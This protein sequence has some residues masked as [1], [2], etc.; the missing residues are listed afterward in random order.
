[1]IRRRIVLSYWIVALGLF[2]P[3]AVFAYIDPATTTYIIQIIT[4]LVVTVGV[5]LSILL[6]RFRMV[7]AKIRYGLYGLLYRLRRE[8]KGDVP[9][10]L[11]G[12]EAETKGDVPCVLPG[13]EGPSELPESAGLLRSARNDE[14]GDFEK[15]EKTKG[16]VP[17]VLPGGEGPSELSASAELLR[18]ARYDEGE[19]VPGGGLPEFALPGYAL[20][21]YA[22]PGAGHPP[23]DEEMAAL[24]EPAGLE[25]MAQT[26]PWTDPADRGFPGRLKAAAPVSFAIAFSFVLIGCLDLAVQN[27][28]DI[29]FRPGEITPALLLLS[30]A[31]SIILLFALALFRGRL[32]RVLVTLALS[33]LVAG[34]IQGNFMNGALGELNG[35]IIYW[36]RF[37]PQMAESVIMWA[38]VAACIF[39][40]LHFAKR[41]RFGAVIVAPLILLVVQAAGFSTAFLDYNKT[42]G[43][44]FWADTEEMLTI[45]GLHS[46]ASGRNAIIF[47]LDR[48]DEDFV[49][50]IEANNP[51]FFDVLDGF[52]KFDDN[53]SQF[54]STFPA[55][56]GLLT[57]NRYIYDRPHSEYLDDA[58]ANARF[59]STLKERGV[60][61]RLFVDRG[62]VYNSIEHLK[63][64]ANNVNMGR[65]EV[66]ARVAL[67]K[68]LKLSGYRYAPMPAKRLFWLSP[69]EFVDTLKLTDANAIYMTNDFAFYENIKGFGLSPSGEELGFFYY[70][71]QGAHGPLNM[72]ENINWK[73]ES[74][75]ESYA[76]QRVAQ[77]TGCFKIVFEYLDQLRALGLYEDATIII[78][79]DHPDY[80]GEE[81][82]KP[83]HTALFVKPAGSA[84]TPLGYSGAPVSPD[85]LPGTIMEGLFGDRAGFAPGY[86]DIEEG[87][88]VVR[89][90]DVNLYRYEITGDGRDFSNWSFIGLFP[91]TWE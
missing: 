64:I 78:S 34:Y 38:L 57:G 59:L 11:P 28:G 89:E 86:L 13:A 67:V 74:A 90:F 91:D 66:N 45:D 3:G 54:A 76:S 51:G 53:I 70:H 81:L 17:C 12:A 36:D 16:D 5:S 21:G 14:G 80:L 8:T 1:M 85:Q 10:V 4:A 71:L 43:Y 41:A 52:T 77:A 61:V 18:S 44:S 65:P 39:L 42:G 72:D 60:D 23:T 2:T 73:E 37:R 63:G 29:P 27:S 26:A 88:D 6:Y 32:Y 55:V 25:K 68:L 47:I 24:G 31:A 69:T 58:W 30:F 46:P 35:E 83:M 79:G 9:C 7:S 56:A 75:E 84:G 40:L 49:M 50:D 48:L 33:V 62:Y 20:P 15:T 19:V 22:I 87:R 82:K